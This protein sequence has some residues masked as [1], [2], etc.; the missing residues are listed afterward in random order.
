MAAHVEGEA[1]ST[2]ES[3]DDLIPA[4]RVESGGVAKQDR[5]ILAGPFVECDFD[6]VNGT[7]MFDG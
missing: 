5:R 2:P 4:A 7:A 3:R 1:V 6:S